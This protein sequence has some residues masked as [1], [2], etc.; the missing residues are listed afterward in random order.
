MFCA[1]GSS[2]KNEKQYTTIILE[3]LRGKLINDTWHTTIR[4]GDKTDI[5]QTDV[6]EKEP[7]NFR[8]ILCFPD[9][10]KDGRVRRGNVTKQI[11]YV[12]NDDW[13]ERNKENKFGLPHATGMT[14]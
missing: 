6:E 3:D 7:F 9:G 8:K 11:Y 10:S 5:T 4:V 2:R 12:V 1:V 13:L 14:Y